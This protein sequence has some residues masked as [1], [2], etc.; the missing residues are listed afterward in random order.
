AIIVVLRELGED[1]LKI[2][3]TIAQRTEPT[4][5]IYPILIASVYA[6]L[7][8]GIQFRVLNVEHLDKLMIE[9]DVL[10]IIEMLQH[11]VA[12]VVEN[13]RARMFACSFPEALERHAIVK[14][15]A[16]VNFIA[17]INACLV[18]SIEDGKPTLCQFL[19]CL[20]DQAS[21]AL[22]PGIDCMPHQRT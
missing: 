22:R 21:R 13:V 19:E 12:R 9:V 1:R 11:K 18:E 4:R 6:T 5:T 20:V 8:C 15:F 16:R 10:E 17:N 14:I 3:L 7:S 2:D